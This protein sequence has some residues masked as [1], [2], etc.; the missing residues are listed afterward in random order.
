MKIFGFAQLRNE[1]S[2][3]NL[4]NW[5]RCMNS[6]C[7]KIFVFDQHSTDGS[8]EIYNRQDHLTVMQASKNLFNIEVICKA[9]LLKLLLKDI[10]PVDWIF[11]M[12]GDTILDGRLCDREHLERLLFEKREFDEVRLGHYNLWRSDI[13]YRTD[14][15]F[16]GLHGGVSAF[17]RN[18]GRLF[19]PEISGLHQRVVPLGMDTWSSAL[20]YSLI[21]KGFATDYQIITK[22]EIYKSRGQC[23]WALD[24]L[25]NEEGLTTELV[26]DEVFPSW[27]KKEKNTDPKFLKP[28][29][30]I[31]LKEKEKG[32]I[33]Y[34]L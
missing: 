4:E 6:V 27:Y 18:N 11:W 25:L 28:I 14:D 34:F 30:E 3:G 10:T 23:G 19:F 9:E 15:Q 5:F 20:P 8:H 29:K 12:D 16:H 31:H 7:D 21:H 32:F 17:W 2:K 33:N 22:Y 26:P 1:K 24:R 13:H